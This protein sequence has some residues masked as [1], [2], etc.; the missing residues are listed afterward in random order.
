MRRSL[1]E[2]M[3][4]PEALT[5]EVLDAALGAAQNA[6]EVV[7]PDYDELAE[8]FC[9]GVPPPSALLASL[10]LSRLGEL[11]TLLQWYRATY[12]AVDPENINDLPF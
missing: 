5:L 11:R 8:V 7:H 2:L 6:L 10:L 9:G 12:R 3:I 4:A 1:P